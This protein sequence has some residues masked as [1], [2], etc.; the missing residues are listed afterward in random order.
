M[1][2]LQE[3]LLMSSDEEAH[4]YMT[5]QLNES[6]QSVSLL[7]ELMNNADNE[8]LSAYK[9]HTEDINKAI[10]WLLA[11]RRGIGLLSKKDTAISPEDK[12]KH[13]S[14]FFANINR[15]R[16]LVNRLSKIHAQQHPDANQS[17][18]NMHSQMVQ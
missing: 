17:M 2:L 15:I 10:D 7:L 3:M 9:P 6:I 16:A 12:K 13:I 8:T 5:Q 4:R 1:Q 11:A 14:R 18:I